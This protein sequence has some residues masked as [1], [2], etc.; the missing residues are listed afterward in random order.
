MHTTRLLTV[1]PSMHCAG[2]VCLARGVCLAWGVCLAGGST[3]P[4]GVCLARGSALPEGGIPACTEADP[5]WTEFLTHAT[6]NITLPQTSFAGSHE[7]R[8]M[9]GLIDES[10]KRFFLASVSAVANNFS[11]VCLSLS[12]QMITSE[13]LM[14][15]TSFLV[16][17]SILIISR[18]SLST[19]IIESR[20]RPKWVKF[21]N[22]NIL[23]ACQ[24]STKTYLKVKVIWRSMSYIMWRSY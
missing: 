13:L 24:H 5:L 8:P 9:W 17:T 10:P 4:E 1:S 20:S 22:S 2:G 16:Y 19:K 14:V 21:H 3:L 7:I 6:E 23:A 18:W 12:I 15:G 11:R